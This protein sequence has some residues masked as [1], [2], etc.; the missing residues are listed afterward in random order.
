MQ[1]CV[2]IFIFFMSEMT[3]VRIDIW[4]EKFDDLVQILQGSA[5][6]RFFITVV[7][8]FVTELA[9]KCVL[10]EILYADDLVLMSKTTDGCRY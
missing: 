7:V 5:L 1:D 8:C 4:P 9:K 3:A 6:S 2:I 10:N